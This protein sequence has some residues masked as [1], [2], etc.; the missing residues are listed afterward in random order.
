MTD[1]RQISIQL[2]TPQWERLLD[3]VFIAA[4]VTARFVETDPEELDADQRAYDALKT[5]LLRKGVVEDDYVDTPI[6]VTV[7]VNT[8]RATR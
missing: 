4:R 6:T 8:P 7:H 2:R 1:D 5:Q 3:L